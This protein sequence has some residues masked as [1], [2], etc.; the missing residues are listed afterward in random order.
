MVA[1][2]IECEKNNGLFSVKQKPCAP[3][4]MSAFCKKLINHSAEKNRFPLGGSREA[5][6]SPLPVGKML[7]AHFFLQLLVN[8]ETGDDEP[9]VHVSHR[10][11]P[12]VA[13][14]P[15]PIHIEG[16]RFAPPHIIVL[17]D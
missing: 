10:L 12:I 5:Q 11:F 7:E 8:P 16:G 1:S 15:R 4:S 13:F 17:L 6:A 3:V 9:I 2:W 14:D